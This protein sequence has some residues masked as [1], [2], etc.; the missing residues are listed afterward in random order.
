MDRTGRPLGVIGAVGR[1]WNPVIAPDGSLR[2]AVDRYEP[3]TDRYRIV[4]IDDR[5]RETTLTHNER[6]RFASFSPDGKWIAYMR[7]GATGSELRR[8]RV[9]GSGGDQLIAASPSSRTDDARIPLDWSSDGRYIICSLEGDLWALPL[10]EPSALLQL[11]RTAAFERTAR[12]SRDGRWLA[13]TSVEGAETAVWVQDFPAGERKSKISADSVHGPSWR[14]DGKELY[15]MT[16]DGSLIAVPVTA[17]STF[18]HG[19]PVT[20]FKT[21]PGPIALSVHPYAATPDGQR[22]LVAETGGP[23]EAITVMLNWTALVK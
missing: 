20:L 6:Q 8:T 17:G 7:I 5:G 22:F 4:T 9:D 10:A 1:D 11:T 15:Y 12:L 23:P 14:A 2:V 19:T 13:Y 21:N 3:A 18:A 16:H